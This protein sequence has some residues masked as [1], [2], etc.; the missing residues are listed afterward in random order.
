VRSEP[1]VFPYRVDELKG[2]VRVGLISLK[3]QGD[4]P[5]G[6][7][8]L[9]DGRSVARQLRLHDPRA[10]DEP[11]GRLLVLL[12]VVIEVQARQECLLGPGESGVGQLGIE[13]LDGQVEVVLQGGRSDPRESEELLASSRRGSEQSARIARTDRVFLAIGA[14][15]GLLQNPAI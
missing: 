10:L 1:E 9:D 14:S 7:E 8:E 6:G 4:V 3:R 5:S 11:I 2:L 15:F 12:A 13:D